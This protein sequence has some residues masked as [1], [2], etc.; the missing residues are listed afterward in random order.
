MRIEYLCHQK[1]SQ[2]SCFVP[3]KR[4]IVA[5]EHSD[6]TTDVLQLRTE[7]IEI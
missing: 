6:E 7:F 5:R 3:W 4:E 2:F 1:C